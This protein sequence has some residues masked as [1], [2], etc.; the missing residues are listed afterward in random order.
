MNKSIV[1]LLLLFT[2]SCAAQK[3]MVK[4]SAYYDHAQKLLQEKD[5]FNAEEYIYGNDQYFTR[6]ESLVLQA[7]MDNI[8]N[9]PA[10]SNEKIAQVLKEFTIQTG[11]SLRLSLLQMKHTNYARLFEY[12]KANEVVKE[13]LAKPSGSLDEAK[14]ADLKNMN[15][16]WALLAGQPKQE[17]IVKGATVIKMTRDKAQLANLPVKAGVATVDFIFD[18][19]ANLSTVNESTAAKL[20]VNILGGSIEVGSITGEKVMA[21]MA[22]CREL[23]IGNIIVKNAVFLVFPDKALAFPQIDYQINGIIGFPVIEAMGE[24]QLTQAD[25]FIVPIDSTEISG[26]PMALDFLMPVI[27]IGEEHYTFDTG[28]VGTSLYSKYFEKHKAEVIAAYKA[29]DLE[30]GGAGGMVT[31]KGYNITFRPVMNGKQLELKDVQLFSEKIGVEEN[32]FYGN[33]GQDLIKQ[34]SKMTISFRSMFVKFD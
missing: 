24:I 10:L 34:F 12:G 19:G 1:P 28:A 29:T 8:F 14:V 17:V 22:I 11:D 23:S 25:E 20:G 3:G 2:L 13:I 9:A 26:Q 30:F 31:K 32:H 27:K 7:N 6:F 21:K 4:V 33:I 5:Y 16:I 15:N 18:T